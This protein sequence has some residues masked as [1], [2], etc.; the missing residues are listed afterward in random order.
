MSEA[1]ST[2]PYGFT[3]NLYYKDNDGNQFVSA[4]FNETLSIVELDEGLDGETF[5][6]YLFMSALVILLLVFFQQYFYSRGVTDYWLDDILIDSCDCVVLQK[7]RSSASTGPE[8]GTA[9]SKGVDYD[10]LPEET[11]HALSKS[12]S[13]ALCCSYIMYLQINH[14]KHLVASCRLDRGRLRRLAMISY[15]NPHKITVIS[16]GI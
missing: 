4:V 3:V 9:N 1:Y 14:P 2:R 10:W 15:H 11:L 5:F 13:F 16:S 8:I 7:K 6:L 12:S